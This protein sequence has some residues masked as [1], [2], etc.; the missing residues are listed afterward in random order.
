MTRGPLIRWANSSQRSGSMTGYK[1]HTLS[2]CLTLT[3]ADW[4]WRQPKALFSPCCLHWVIWAVTVK[5]TREI[6]M[7]THVYTEK[8]M[9]TSRH[10]HTA[11]RQAGAHVW[12]SVEKISSLVCQTV[13]QSSSYQIIQVLFFTRGVQNWFDFFRIHCLHKFSALLTSAQNASNI[14]CITMRHL[15]KNNTLCFKC[16]SWFADVTW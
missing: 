14:S 12:L 9:H 10:T 8:C 7:H 1:D 11:G 16:V 5:Q 15:Y 13:N 3:R 4:Q 6:I 2:C